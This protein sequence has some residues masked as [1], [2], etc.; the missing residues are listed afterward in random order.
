MFLNYYAELIHEDIISLE[1]NFKGEYETIYMDISDYE[2]IKGKR[3]YKMKKNKD[4]TYIQFV[5]ENGKKVSIHRFFM[6][7]FTRSEYVYFANGNW[8]DLRKCNLKVGRA[9]SNQ[10]D[11][12]IAELRKL[13]KKQISIEKILKSKNEAAQTSSKKSQPHF[14]I[15]KNKSLNEF[16]L[17][18]GN[19]TISIKGMSDSQSMEYILNLINSQ[20]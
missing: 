19:Q 11:K 13:E 18:M 9:G 6:N 14:T 1:C 12:F 3:L 4:T 20:N 15:E 8:R 17:D 2:K 5:D 7:A 16:I 10:D